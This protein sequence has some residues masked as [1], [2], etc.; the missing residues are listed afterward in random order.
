MTWQTWIAFVSVVSALVALPG[1]AVLMALNL[2]ARNGYRGAA[3]AI[4]GNISGLAIM[5]AASALGIGGLMKT[6][7][8]AFMALKIAGGAYLIYLGVKMIRAKERNTP[9]PITATVKPVGPARRYVEGVGV[10][11]SNPKAILFCAALFPQFLNSN[12][13]AWP[14]LLILGATMM[15]LSFIGLS[16]YAALAKSVAKKT[17]AGTSKIYERI[18]GALFIALGIGIALSRR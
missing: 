14:Q 13:S 7:A 8:M 2:G 9:R 4:V 6:S 10:A 3:P 11:L 12:A 16:M 17:R 5:I 1:P 18:S 15:S